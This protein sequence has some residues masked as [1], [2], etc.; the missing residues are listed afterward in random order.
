MSLTNSAACSGV[1][2]FTTI[3]SNV[4]A[5]SAAS[6]LHF[7]RC[8]VNPRSCISFAVCSNNVPSSTRKPVS[9]WLKT[10]LSGSRSFWFWFSTVVVRPIGAQRARF[11]FEF[12]LDLRNAC[13]SALDP[14]Q[15]IFAIRA[16]DD[17]DPIFAFAPECSHGCSS[18]LRC[19]SSTELNLRSGRPCSGIAGNVF[20]RLPCAMNA[21]P[22]AIKS[23]GNSDQ[24]MNFLRSI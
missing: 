4:S 12:F 5:I 10:K 18:R 7:T 22:Y 13:R 2:P 17:A 15:L 1:A 21:L 23:S 14:S 6:S 8:G 11:Q 24:V 20:I 3:E 16:I 19:Q 9:S